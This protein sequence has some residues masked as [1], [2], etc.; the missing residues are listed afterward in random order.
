MPGSGADAPVLACDDLIAATPDLPARAVIVG[1]NWTLVEGPSGTGLAA[2]PPRSQSHTT[3]DTGRFTGRSLRC[4]AGLARAGNLYE[5]AIGCAAINAGVNRFDLPEAGRNGLDLP[6]DATGPVVVV[7]RFPRLSQKLPG[8]VVCC[9]SATRVAPGDLPPLQNEL[10]PLPTS[11]PVAGT[12]S[13]RRQPG[14]RQ[15][16]LR[17]YCASA[18]AHESH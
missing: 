18:P 17:N 8:A 4:L 11:F 12:W 1:Y 6:D 15:A 2:T 5:R 14:S 7:G 3:D 13:S 16:V 10:K 9:S